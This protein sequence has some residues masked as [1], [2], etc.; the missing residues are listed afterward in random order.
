MN[1]ALLAFV[2]LFGGSQI[3]EI[4]ITIRVKRASQE[5]AVPSHKPTR[6]VW[7][8]VREPVQLGGGID[9]GYELVEE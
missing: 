4:N 6:K 5:I 2:F 8:Q 7:R 1:T 3:D 9:D